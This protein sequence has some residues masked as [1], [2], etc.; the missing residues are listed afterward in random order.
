MH[1]IAPTYGDV[2]VQ[3][4]ERRHTNTLHLDPRDSPNQ[5]NL[6][7]EIGNK[8][9]NLAEERSLPEGVTWLQEYGASVL[10]AIG[11]TMSLL[12][13]TLAFNATERQTA[14]H[15]G[16]IAGSLVSGVIGYPT[17]RWVTPAGTAMLQKGSRA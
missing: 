3:K 9:F 6:P 17:L 14:V 8:P 7:L 5:A 15:L 12:I 2:A 4:V 13:T 10:A 11:F 1:S 16:V